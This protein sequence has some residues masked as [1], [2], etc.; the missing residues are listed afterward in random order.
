MGAEIGAKDSSRT[1]SRGI[2]MA[3]HSQRQRHLEQV[4]ADTLVPRPKEPRG[5]TYCA[6]SPARSMIGKYMDQ[7]PSLHGPCRPR[8]MGAESACVR[9]IP[10]NGRGLTEPEWAPLGDSNCVRPPPAPKPCCT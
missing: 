5:E 8:V 4:K 9:R 6:Y 2:V 10:T 7:T 1:G 3:R